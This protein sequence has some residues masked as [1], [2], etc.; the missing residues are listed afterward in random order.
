MIIGRTPAPAVALG[1]AFDSLAR[2][3]VVMLPSRIDE[4]KLKKSGMTRRR[5]GAA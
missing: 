1:G 5:G 4:E 3:T 2:R